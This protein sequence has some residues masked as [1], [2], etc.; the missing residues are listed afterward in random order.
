MFS[1]QSA[2]HVSD[3]TSYLV[4]YKLYTHTH[5]LVV[6][7]EGVV[8]STFLLHKQSL[9]TVKSSS[10]AAEITECNIVLCI[11]I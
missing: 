3:T 2:D 6:K 5:K 11:V 9:N 4:M 1:L 8:V 10:A 7:Y